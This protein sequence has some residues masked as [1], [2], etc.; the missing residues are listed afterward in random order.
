MT[1]NTSL[2]YANP[3]FPFFSVSKFT[4]V[5]YPLPPS[6]ISHPIQTTGTSADT[7]SIKIEV[8]D[9]ETKAE[10][11][12][13]D[14]ASV[15][16]TLLISRKELLE[17][18]LKLDKMREQGRGRRKERASKMNMLHSIVADGQQ[19]VSLVR[20]SFFTQQGSPLD[21][22]SSPGT[23]ASG[24]GH[25][26]PDRGDFN[27][28]L[29]PASALSGFD[30]NNYGSS[31]NSNSAGV[32]SSSGAIRSNPSTA[33]RTTT[34]SSAAFGG[35]D[36]TEF[37]DFVTPADV[38]RKQAERMTLAEI[39]EMVDRYS[40]RDS[41][42]QK[43]NQLEVDL[44]ETVAGQK[45]KK[46]QLSEEIVQARQK[47][48]QLASTRQV[49]Q[50]VENQT[51]SLN[52]VK[53]E[54]EECKEKDYRLKVNLVTLKRSIPRLLSK[55]TKVA[56]PVPTDMQLHDAVNRLMAEISKYFKEISQ[57]LAKDATAEDVATNG[58]TSDDEKQSEIDKLHNM[59]V[60]THFV[61]FA[62]GVLLH[63]DNFLSLL[64]CNTFI[65]SLPFLVFPLQSYL[66]LFVPFGLLIRHT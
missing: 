34:P 42:L 41:R 49:Y 29:G 36:N 15:E 55:L 53:K 46:L 25:R 11:I 40:S 10:K 27:Y 59:Y 62:L 2:A 33:A 66:P 19:S 3:P 20:S 13:H 5:C 14:V 58:T 48:A 7:H 65:F 30:G 9:I 8:V 18:E 16:A 52:A 4:F 45:T 57:E 12:R 21:G 37:D 26:S 23:M 50:D 24:A 43:L 38:P 56:H 6:H 47:V 61:Y 32:H 1:L 51:R 39:E 64:L 35:G 31:N 60:P 63:F 54:Y 28:N 22:T 44:K 17:R